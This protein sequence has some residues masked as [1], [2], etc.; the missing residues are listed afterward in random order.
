MHDESYWNE[1]R[2]FNSFEL[3]NANDKTAIW[4]TLE[5]YWNNG[6]PS[7][8]LHPKT[9]SYSPRAETPYFKIGSIKVDPKL[10]TR[11]GTDELNLLNGNH[12]DGTFNMLCHPDTISSNNSFLKKECENEFIF[13]PTASGRTVALFKD[14]KFVT[15]IKLHYPM[16][17]GRYS[18]D[19]HLHKWLASLERSRLM[20]DAYINSSIRWSFFEEKS[21]HFFSSLDSPGFGNILRSRSPIGIDRNEYLFVPAFS[22][23]CQPFNGDSTIY[24]SLAEKYGWDQ[25]IAIENFITSVITMYLYLALDYGILP[26]LNSQ[27]IVFSV[28]K[29]TGDVI[30]CIRDMQ[31]VYIDL[32]IAKTVNLVN[33]K[34]L[35]HTSPHKK[36][37][38]SFSFDFKLGRYF[39]MPMYSALHSF[40]SSKDAMFT[41]RLPSS[42]IELVQSRLDNNPNY[43]DGQTVYGY[44]KTENTMEHKMIPL[45]NSD[46]RRS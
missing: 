32:E 46:L 23:F 5:R 9:W 41:S 25:S 2:S 10:V 21:G 26:E 27:N 3:L 22:L 38:R 31:D 29:E 15:Q 40:Y 19:L 14:N 20:K 39:L 35:K 4:L 43:F 30:P 18:R 12:E 44:A 13:C 17:L 34:V 16:I 45:G 36:Q 33:Y 8:F 1:L 28:N 37:R 7:G 42:V 6:S 24:K 11:F